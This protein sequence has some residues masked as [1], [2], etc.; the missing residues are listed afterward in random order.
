MHSE[1]SK[2]FKIITLG[3]KVNQ[4]E[5]SFFHEALL[6]HGFFED[7]QRPHIAIINTCIV[8]QTASHQSRQEIRKA[9]RENPEALVVATGCYAQTFPDELAQIQGLDLIIGNSLKSRLPELLLHPETPEHKRIYNKPFSPGA[10]FDILPVSRFPNRSRAFLKIQDGCEACCTYCIVP[11]SRGH[12]RSMP[13]ADVLK[14]MESFAD[15][16]YKEIVLTGIHLGKYGLDLGENKNLNQLLKAVGKEDFPF[17]I[18]LS[19]LEVN[20]IDDELIEMVA[21]E[22]WLCRHFHVPLQSGDGSLLKRM[23]R[24]YSPMDFRRV[25]QTI[26]D[27]IPHAAIGVDVICGFPGEDESMYDNTYGLIKDMPVSYLHVFPFSPRPGTAAASFEGRLDSSVIKKRASGMRTLGKEKRNM[28]YKSCVKHVFPV[29][30]E[31]WYEEEEGL[32]KGRTDNYLPVIFPMNKRLNRFISVLIEKNTG[33]MLVG[34]PS[35]EPGYR[36]STI[37]TKGVIA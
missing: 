16:G 29:L 22:Q 19:S 2:S 35:E 34:S 25:I 4:Y 33:T 1:M 36:H 24:H 20:E 23:N 17:R 13:S 14:Q 27:K 3:C 8:T 7:D 32:I 26:Y 18:R 11:R 5:S 28:F 15:Q 12:Y 9:V 37:E 21:S 30:P 10:P 31:D 6:K